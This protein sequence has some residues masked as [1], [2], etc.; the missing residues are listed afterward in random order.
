M[1]ESICGF[2]LSF[3]GQMKIIFAFL[4]RKTVELYSFQRN[5]S[6][7]TIFTSAVRKI[8]IFS[9]YFQIYQKNFVQNAVIQLPLPVCMYLSN[10]FWNKSD[11]WSIIQKIDKILLETRLWESIWRF[12]LSFIGQIN[13]IFV[14]L[15]R[16]TV[17]LHYF[18]WNISRI[19]IFTS[20]DR[21]IFIFSKYLQIWLINFIQNAVIQLPSPVSIYLSNYFCN[22][23]D[24]WKIIPENR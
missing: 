18:Y 15:A 22:K 9:K 23:S 7:I 21:K 2:F 20:G 1:W 17:E 10:Y 6:I 19:M 3:L 4:A 11:G 12:F 5:I 16:N 8:R 13:V 24:T 14:F